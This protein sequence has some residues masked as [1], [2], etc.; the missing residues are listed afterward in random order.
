MNAAVEAARAGEQGRGFAVVAGE[1]RTL[2]QRSGLA[3]KEIRD[4]I[5]TSVVQ[6]STGVKQ[7]GLA[8]ATIDEVVREVRSVSTLVDEIRHATNEQ[9][10]GLM[11]I[12]AAIV[13][14]DN[15]TQQNAAMVEETNASANSLESGSKSLTRSVSVFR[16]P[17]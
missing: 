7:M 2:A 11:Q 12:N 1:V 6:V 15:V 3:A 9:A 16:L 13:Q 8:N 4:L 5:Q 10:D 17:R 14:L